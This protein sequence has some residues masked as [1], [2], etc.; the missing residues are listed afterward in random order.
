[1]LSQVLY[2]LSWPVFIYISYLAIRY[3]IKKLELQ[4][5]NN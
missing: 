5:R 3:F 2:L 4:L 1:M